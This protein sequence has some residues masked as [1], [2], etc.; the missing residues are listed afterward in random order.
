MIYRRYIIVWDRSIPLKLH[1][2]IGPI[3]VRLQVH[4][5]NNNVHQIGYLDEA[6]AWMHIHHFTE[7]TQRFTYKKRKRKNNTIWRIQW[8]RSMGAVIFKWYI[9][10]SYNTWSRVRCLSICHA[11]CIRVKPIHIISYLPQCV[12]VSVS[13]Y[14]NT[15]RVISQQWYDMIYLSVI[16]SNKFTHFSSDCDRCIPSVDNHNGAIIS[17]II[18]CSWAVKISCSVF[19]CS[20]STNPSK[21]KTLFVIQFQRVNY[22]VCV[23][24]QI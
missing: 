12:R 15:H 4:H 17:C 2:S 13:A 14:L 3:S 5:D 7:A 1:I 24:L 9:H 18:F 22:I 19:H 10:P 11:Q 20:A 6:L 16:S 23:L 8:N 21:F